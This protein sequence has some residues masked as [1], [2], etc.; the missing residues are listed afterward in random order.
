MINPITS[1]MVKYYEQ[2]K[3]KYSR[4]VEH[5]ITINRNG[6]WIKENIDSGYR[7]IAAKEIKDNILKKISIINLD[8]NHELANKIYSET[9]DIS[10]N[11]WILNDVVIIT[12]E[13]GLT[14]KLLKENHEISSKYDYV[15][16]TSL[17]RNLDA[18][19]FLDLL[20]H[21]DDLKNKGYNKRY[22]DQN[23]NSMLSLPF[24]LFL[25]AAI[26]A[27]LTMNTL[28]KSNNFTFIVVGLITC[29]A[30]YYFK[31]LSLALG[32]TN[33]ISLSLA[34]W[35]PVVIIG[36]FTSIGILQINEK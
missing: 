27:I 1:T 14:K 5:L 33:R 25:M 36:L 28:K 12:F 35:V 30:V 11:K 31:D 8:N 17:F 21:Y 6:L 13:D 34:A 26:A 20:I 7:I 3:S 16:I 2:T 10:N 9:A 29:V 24:F 15:K 4:D 19:S 18:M 22:L 32:Q 23:L